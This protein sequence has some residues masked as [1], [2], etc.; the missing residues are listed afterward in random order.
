MK[1]I[2]SERKELI[3]TSLAYRRKR[4]VHFSMPSIFG[5]ID[6]R[7]SYR[8][9]R[10][11]IPGLGMMVENGGK[12]SGTLSYRNSGYVIFEGMANTVYRV[13]RSDVPIMPYTYSAGQFLRTIYTYDYIVKV[14]DSSTFQ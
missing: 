7:A 5:A 12:S 4:C 10:R 13:S 11:E 3:P 9:D 14:D 1:V 2:L 8:T 6:Q